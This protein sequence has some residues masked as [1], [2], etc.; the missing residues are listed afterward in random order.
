M[1]FSIL[2]CFWGWQ[3]TFDSGS[4]DNL[5]LTLEQMVDVLAPLEIVGEIVSEIVVVLM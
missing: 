3:K 1:S 5:L 4:N 2:Y